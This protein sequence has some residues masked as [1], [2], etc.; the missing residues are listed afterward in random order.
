METINQVLPEVNILT[1]SIGLYSEGT[2]ESLKH[3]DN[4]LII[5]ET[6]PVKEPTVIGNNPTDLVRVDPVVQEVEDTVDTSL[7]STNYHVMIIA[8]SHPGQAC[9]ATNRYNSVQGSE[10]Q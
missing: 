3:R 4:V 7:A 10:G 1:A 6:V 8:G 2:K 5:F 9:T